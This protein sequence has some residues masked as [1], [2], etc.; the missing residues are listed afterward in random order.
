MLFSFPAE[1]AQLENI[2]MTIE[3]NC[4]AMACSQKQLMNIRLSAEE[5][6]VN[7]IDYAEQGENGGIDIRIT[8]ESDCIRL[9]IEDDGKYFNPTE[10]PDPDITKPLAERKPGGLGI[11][12][13]KKLAKSFTYARKDGKNIN[14]IVFVKI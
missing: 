10:K 6:I 13:V 8:D 4:A 1:K 3:K 11:F 2:M 7:I 14:T 12:F 5:V 9:E